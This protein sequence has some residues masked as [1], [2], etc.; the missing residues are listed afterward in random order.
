[1]NPTQPWNFNRSFT[2]YLTISITRIDIDFRLP[3]LLFN[4]IIFFSFLFLIYISYYLLFSSTICSSSSLIRSL[5]SS[6]HLFYSNLFLIFSFLISWEKSVSV[7]LPSFILLFYSNR[8]ILHSLL[9]LLFSILSFHLFLTS[10]GIPFPSLS[11]HSQAEL[12]R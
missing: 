2:L 9:F 3:P 10:F 5:F 12:N 8:T 7:C 6:S 11:Y 1:M 4:S